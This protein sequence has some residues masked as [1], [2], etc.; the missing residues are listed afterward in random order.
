MNSSKKPQETFSLTDLNS[1]D[2]KY[3]FV[4]GSLKK[5]FKYH[6]VFGFNHQTHFIKSTSLTGYKMY[7]LG[8]RAGIKYSGKHRDQV[9]GELYMITNP[10]L[11]DKLIAWETGGNYE[12]IIVRSDDNNFVLF[13]VY[14]NIPVDAKRIFNGK[15]IKRNI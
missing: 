6:K 14:E 4:Y 3:V 13:F 7:D 9:H 11:Y 12:P 8:D 5:G 1:N 15:W 10:L 2:I